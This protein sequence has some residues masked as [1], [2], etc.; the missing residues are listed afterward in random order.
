MKQTMLISG[1]P[2]RPHG[3]TALAAPLAF[4]LLLTLALVP[5]VQAQQAAPPNAPSGAPAKPGSDK[6]IVVP[7]AVLAGVLAGTP[8]GL[9]QLRQFLASDSASPDDVTARAIK[10]VQQ[11]K[12][13]K[14]SDP[15][16][17]IA[18]A[19]RVA[20]TVADSLNA[21]RVMELKVDK[22]FRVPEGAYAFDFGPADKPTTEGFQRVQPND[23]MVRG[24]TQQ[25]LHRPGDG[26]P[27]LSGGITGVEGLSVNVPDGE[28][29]VILMTEALGDAAFSLAPFGQQI[30]ANGQEMN[31]FNT[32]PEDWL[33]QAVLSQ[34]GL[35]GAEGADGKRRGGAITLNVKVQGGKLIMDFHMAGAE[36]LLKTYL[37]GMIIQPIEQPPLMART[38]DADPGNRP[39]DQQLRNE[40]QLAQA[41]ANVLQDIQP[42][43]GP[44]DPTPPDIPPLSEP[45]LFASPS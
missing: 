4:G 9:Q 20:Q 32:S 21:A 42:A 14:V 31:I 23:P 1:K 40:A 22:Q 13:S 28:Y 45:T 2:L 5:A 30:V 6:P 36:Q 10:I 25:G 3:F 7:P 39:V 19:D 35:Q 43:A 12:D 41:L 11:L 29:R 24:A 8:E 27:I 33:K 34:R 18:A 26:E 44:R 16:L 17:V 37:T 15:S 38:E